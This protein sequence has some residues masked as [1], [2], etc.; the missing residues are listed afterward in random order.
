[1]FSA[2]CQ[3]LSAF[4]RSLPAVNTQNVTLGRKAE[5][6]QKAESETLRRYDT[7]VYKDPYF[8]NK[9]NVLIFDMRNEKESLFTLLLSFCTRS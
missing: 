1:M 6:Q 9:F 3:R 5:S 2:K 4:R 8:L 7:L